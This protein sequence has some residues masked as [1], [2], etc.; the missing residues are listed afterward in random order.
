MLSSQCC[1]LYFKMFFSYWPYWQESQKN[2]RLSGQ[3]WL[4]ALDILPLNPETLWLYVFNEEVCIIIWVVWMWRFLMP[5][6]HLRTW[7][8]LI[9]TE[10]KCPGA[11]LLLKNLLLRNWDLITVAVTHFWRQGIMERRVIERPVWGIRLTQVGIVMWHPFH[12]EMSPV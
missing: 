4:G 2:S 5:E 3:I 10:D 9:S 8:L 1:A 11:I 6:W 7:H 12:L